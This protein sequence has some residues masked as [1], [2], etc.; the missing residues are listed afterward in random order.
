MTRDT[1]NVQERKKENFISI[2]GA[3]SWYIVINSLD[4]RFLQCPCKSRDSLYFAE[5]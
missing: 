4:H 5:N 2:K 1:N 3:M